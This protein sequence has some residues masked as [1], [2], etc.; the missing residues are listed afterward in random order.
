MV[1]SVFEIIKANFLNNLIPKKFF[2]KNL[3][4]WPPFIVE[5]PTENFVNVG[6]FANKIY[7]HN[8]IAFRTSCKKYKAHHQTLR[9]IFTASLGHGKAHYAD[10][11]EAYYCYRLI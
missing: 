9:S 7:S 11:E 6:N 3:A 2:L 1:F 10:C 8:S 4:I 5:F